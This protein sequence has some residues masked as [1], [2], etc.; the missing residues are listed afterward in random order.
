MNQSSRLLA[1]VAYL[2]SLPG[3]LIVLLTQRSDPFATHHARQSL[4]IALAA[5]VTPL[6]WGIVAWLL[7]WIPVI[8]P[9]LGVALFALVLATYTLLIVSWVVGM[10]VSLQGVLWTM[11]LLGRWIAP[12]RPVTSVRKPLP[13]LAEQPPPAVDI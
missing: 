11:P 7:A 8:G 4:A 1:F 12:Q 3:A 13:E 6:I 5:I 2:L 9:M 10:V